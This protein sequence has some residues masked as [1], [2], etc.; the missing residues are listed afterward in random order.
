MGYRIIPTFHLVDGPNTCSN[1]H[2]A[3]GKGMFIQ[4][5]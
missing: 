4:V 2:L 1:P 5:L 3:V